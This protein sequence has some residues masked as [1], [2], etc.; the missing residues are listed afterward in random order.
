MSCRKTADRLLLRAAFWLCRVDV[1]I[2]SFAAKCSRP[3]S[4]SKYSS[5]LRA[6]TGPTSVTIAASFSFLLWLGRQTP[7]PAA[8]APPPRASSLSL[9]LFV[10]RDDVLQ[11]RLS[12]RHP[13]WSRGMPP[14]GRRLFS[15]LPVSPGRKASGPAAPSGRARM[16]LMAFSAFL[17][18]KTRGASSVPRFN[19]ASFSTVKLNKS[20]G[21]RTRPAFHQFVRHDS[22][23]ALDVQRAAR[24][25]KLHPPRR[26][27][28]AMEVFAAPGDKFR[29]RARTGPPQTGHLP[30][31]C[32][33]KIER[34]R[35]R[36]AVSTP[37]RR[38][39]PESPRPPFR[40]PPCRRCGCPFV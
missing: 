6:T 40:S 28:R 16:A 13:R 3:S 22:A 34:P 36:R 9:F 12:R 39:P 27:R 23:H 14:V 10:I 33:S 18:P 35:A 25:E 38:P 24:G 19:S 11:Q 7:P 37:P 4:D 8:A 31:I 20:S 29:D 32:W 5:T 17:R 15:R 30:P 1:P 2:P 26:L 21:S